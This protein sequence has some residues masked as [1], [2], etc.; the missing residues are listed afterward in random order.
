VYG[1]GVCGID[2]GGVAVMAKI[3]R[4]LI[5]GPKPGREGPLT[6]KLVWHV[7]PSRLLDRLKLGIRNKIVRK[8]LGKGS[9]VL[10]KA[11]RAF[12]RG[13]FAFT[14]NRDLR[15]MCRLDSLR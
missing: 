2:D 4:H 13:R 9:A 3:P 11:I 12:W 8:A 1:D 15:D 7:E 5:A 10:R 14:R 6:G